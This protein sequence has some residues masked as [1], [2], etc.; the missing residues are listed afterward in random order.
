MRILVLDDDMGEVI[1]DMLASAGHEAE[2]AVDGDQAFSMYLKDGPFDLILCD[3]EHPGMSA[4]DLQKAI[5]A[6]NPYQP[7]AFVTGYPI[8][9]KPFLKKELLE[10]IDQIGRP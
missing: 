1:K 9:R 3:L 5:Y 2:M 7:F 4:V 8:L 10:F 6:R